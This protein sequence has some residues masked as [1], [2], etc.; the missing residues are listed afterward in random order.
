MF[1][2]RGG[3][4]LCFSA[5]LSISDSI[6]DHRM[7]LFYMKKEI[8]S[9]DPSVSLGGFATVFM[10]IILMLNVIIFVHDY[11]KDKIIIWRYFDYKY[12]WHI[13]ASTLLILYNNPNKK[14]VILFLPNTV[15]LCY[16]RRNVSF[17][18]PRNRPTVDSHVACH[19]VVLNLLTLRGHVKLSC[20]LWF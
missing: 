5:C 2:E 20:S 12:F 8:K 13:F 16:L 6:I 17:K 19:H 9:L 14:L 15:Y 18:M 1:Y 11:Y 7:C 4:P 3:I 10:L